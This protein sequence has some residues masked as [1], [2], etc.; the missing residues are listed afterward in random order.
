MSNAFRSNIDE[1]YSWIKTN[2]VQ[3]EQMLWVFVIVGLIVDIATTMIGI[4]IGLNESNPA[5]RSAIADYGL[6]GLIFLKAFALFVGMVCRPL[7]DQVYRPIIPAGIA[8]PW[9]VAALIN[10]YMIMLVI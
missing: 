10:T 6:W 8:V 3:V 7:I 2:P 5:A 9:I 4:H 1:G